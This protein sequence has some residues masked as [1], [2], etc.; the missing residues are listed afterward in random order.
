MLWKLG[1][2]V[3]A[4]GIELQQSWISLEQGGHQQNAA[5]AI[6]NVGGVQNGKK[7]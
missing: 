7:Q 3:T 1:S 4:I 6:L 2:L 5:I